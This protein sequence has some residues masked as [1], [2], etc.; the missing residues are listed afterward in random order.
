MKSR[1]MR[2]LAMLLVLASLVSMFSVFAFAETTVDSV[3]EGETGEDVGTENDPFAEVLE[4]YPKFE[5]N[6]QR[7]FAE[8]W[9][10]LNG[11]TFTDRG[12]ELYIDNETTV[13]YK[14]NY[15]M[16]FEI[17]SKENTYAQWAFDN[18]NEVGAVIEFDLKADDYCHIPGLVHFATPGGA[19]NERTNVNMMEIKDGVVYIV[20]EYD[21]ASKLSPIVLEDGSYF[22]LSN[23]WTHFAFVLDFTY[24]PLEEKVDEETGEPI[25][26]E[27]TGE[28]IYEEG[29]PY[30]KLF[31]LTVYY[32]NS[33]EYAETGELEMIATDMEIPAF[34]NQAKG[35]QFVR[36]GVSG[37]VNESDYG[38]SVCI[39]NLVG[40][41]G[42][43]EYGLATPEMGNGSKCDLGYAQ[44]VTIEGGSTTVKGTMDYINQGLAM[45]VNV[46]YMRA[47][48][49][50]TPIFED[51]NGNAYGAPIKVDGVVYVPFEAILNGI[52]YPYYIHDDG[53]FID[54]STGS[55]ASYISIGKR[56][57]TISGTRVELEVAP[58]IYNDVIYIGVNDVKTII[59]GWYADYDE[60]G[61][62]V[63]SQ[64]EDP[65]DRNFNANLMMDI[66]KEFVFEYVT[67]EQII[68]DVDKNTNGFDH[69][70]LLGN[71]ETFDKLKAVY[72][73]EPGDE[74]YD[75]YLTSRLAN[76]VQ[77]GQ[78]GFERY[79]K[80]SHTYATVDKNWVVDENGEP[81]LVPVYENGEQVMEPMLDENGEVVYDE[82]G[83]AIMVPVMTKTYYDKYRFYT[84]D[85]S[86]VTN[87]Q[88]ITK[89]DEVLSLAGDKLYYV[90]GDEEGNFDLENKY[91]VT[92]SAALP[93]DLVFDAYDWEW[94]DYVGLM[95]D[96][97]QLD[98][99]GSNYENYALEMPYQDAY[100]YDRE[101]GR[102]A[103]SNRTTYVQYMACAWQIS[104]DIKYVL[105]A[106][107]M[108]LRLGEWDHWGPGHFLNCADG[109]VL[110]AYFY[111]WCYDALV[112]LANG[113]A[114][115]DGDGVDD[116]D[117]SVVDYYG[118]PA[119]HYDVN[120]IY[121]ILYEKAVYEGYIAS[122]EIFTEWQSPI[123]GTGGSIYHHRENNWNAVCTS[124]MVIDA[125]CLLDK[126]N[127]EN[128][129]PKYVEILAN[130]SWLIEDNIYGLLTY[131]M[132]QYMPD[133]SYIE[134][135]GYWSYGT[136]NFFELCMA[137][138]SAA[139]TN[140]GMMDCWGIDTTC[141]FACQTE[142]SD[143]RTFN[144]HDGG[145]SSQDSSFFF[146]VADYFGDN[147]L[148]DVRMNHLK[149]GKGLSIF[150]L[151]YYPFNGT[152]AGE[153]MALD[154]YS[155]NID[156]YTARSSWEPGAVF[157]GMMGGKNL[158]THGQCDGGSFVYH[159]AGKVWFIDL[160]TEEYN[161][162]GF[163]G[164]ATRYRY[165]VMKP[166]GNNTITLTSDP[167]VLP[168]GQ[169]LN[170][171]C[172]M[173][174]TDSNEHG[175]YAIFD[176]SEALKGAAL[177]WYRGM[178]LTNDRKTTIIQD[179]INFQTAQDIYWFGHYS[180]SYVTQVELSN[181]GRTAYMIS[182]TN[183]QTQKVLRVKIVSSY[184]NLKFTIMGTGDEDI[185]H[186]DPDTGTFKSDYA[187][188]NGNRVPEKN[189]SNYKKLA[190]HASGAMGFNVAVVIE[191]IDPQT[192]GTPNEI[193]VGYT[194]D[195]SKRETMFDWVPSADMRGVIIDD[196]DDEKLLRG[197]Q[198]PGIIPSNVA[199]IERYFGDGT[200]LTSN[201]D[202]VY[203]SLTDL[204]YVIG[205]FRTDPELDKFKSQ[206]EKFDQYKAQYDAYA[207]AV[208]EILAERTLLTEILMGI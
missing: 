135:P 106:Y 29:E 58:G 138:D 145:M 199:R 38:T 178:L 57:A 17:L 113:T 87:L 167:K 62:I 21:G 119:S 144:F 201:I 110:V 160:G 143:Y 46:E 168:V 104:R 111:D 100:G 83:D 116:F 7:D 89:T 134:S 10:A 180:L 120:T 148:A 80:W 171:Y 112:A 31:K 86:L 170:A 76:I 159:N 54:I 91:E 33:N 3:V 146:Y 177:S 60:L 157:I 131:G 185:V 189:R 30:E 59:P 123:V 174:Q 44:S 107:D 39:D 50:R 198:N 130:S 19:A 195:A 74:D 24:A 66:M 72:N 55:G 147:G 192:K 208:N 12:S 152:E 125:L 79:A 68:E 25:Y 172:P 108:V 186:N 128:L 15:F 151:F 196:E 32:G 94:K 82:N 88:I 14:K 11:F 132:M 69:P 99:Y 2:M 53:E 203:Y 187:A 73:A 6:Y 23:E 67:A 181:D 27:E 118:K 43:N 207:E 18:K 52:E 81:V 164:G 40:Y 16:R 4:K 92:T 154:Y 20:Q 162:A 75:S 121:D 153:P 127:E 190:I 41:T 193:G 158:V 191:E 142:S 183:P 49:V 63:I 51:E 115:I 61:L 184:T 114:D 136:N 47:N 141:L 150:D 124:G 36:W 140:Y 48:K 70:Y 13:D 194:Y 122:L 37:T 8:G 117:Q 103:V 126:A 34:Q 156:I 78:N 90:V 45:K 1:F 176:M 64:H 179:E 35:I 166:E 85:D 205:F 197:K 169:N 42:A 65:I 101:G 97:E 204:E 105:C 84:Q 188:N 98:Y 102:S 137:L 5:L 28:P 155:K 175:S 96:A 139:G 71:Q 202:S 149:G 200:A 163:W 9:D 22:R 95:T 206:V 26:D 93:D 182:G 56:S 133:G 129:D 165:Y 109:S 161:A 77:N 173:V